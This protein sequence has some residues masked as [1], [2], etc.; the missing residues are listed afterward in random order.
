MKDRFIAIKAQ[1]D[2]IEK[3][4]ESDERQLLDAIRVYQTALKEILEIKADDHGN[5]LR[6]AVNIAN[7]ALNDVQL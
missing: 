5:G 3:M 7:G 6:L 2:A 4:A 1:L